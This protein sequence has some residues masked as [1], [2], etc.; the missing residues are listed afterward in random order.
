MFDTVSAPDGGFERIFDQVLVEVRDKVLE[1][2][3]SVERDVDCASRTEA[4][5][6]RRRPLLFGK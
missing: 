1:R 2:K 3:G 6:Q 4:V 5:A